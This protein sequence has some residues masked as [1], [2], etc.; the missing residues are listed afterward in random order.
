[1]SLREDP[2]EYIIKRRLEK[3]RF[4]VPVMSYKG[5]VGKTVISSLLALAASENGHRV[6]LLDLDFTNPSL[7]LVLGVDPYKNKPAEEK[8]VIPP[9]INS[10]SFMSL[11]FYTRDNP[12]PLRGRELYEIYRELL[13]ITIWG[14]K[15]FLVIDHPP[16]LTDISLDTINL[17]GKY[18]RPLIV[19][20]ASKLSLNPTINLVKIL[21]EMS[22][23]P[24]GVVI[25]L[26]REDEELKRVIE[27]AFDRNR[28]H[29]LGYINYDPDLEKSLGS[30]ES[31]KKTQIY[32]VVR[33]RIF[34][35]V[36]R[37]LGA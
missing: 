18:S 29:L 16:S 25:N 4:I 12:S 1:M 31:L 14:E 33:E 37:V 22:I 3:I 10:I 6:G 9:T 30:I 34:R 28:I 32:R 15:D 24:I 26:Y 36:A 5:G 2:R 19:S 11:V 13:S 17:L 7:H 23:E 20:T 27:E 21:R 8:G 35:E